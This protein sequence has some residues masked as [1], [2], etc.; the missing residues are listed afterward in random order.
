[1]KTPYCRHGK[2]HAFCGICSYPWPV[3]LV[4]I[5]WLLAVTLARM[6]VIK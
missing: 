1:M 6:G 4:F 2:Y 5:A 3:L